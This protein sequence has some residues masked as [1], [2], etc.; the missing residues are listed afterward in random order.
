MTTTQ[1]DTQDSNTIYLILDGNKTVDKTSF[2]AQISE[3]LK[4]PD[5][6]SAN[7]DA[8]NDCLNHPEDWGLDV[9]YI[10]SITVLWLDPISFSEYNSADFLT[11]LDIL[12]AFTE[13]KNNPL[14]FI[15]GTNVTKIN[16]SLYR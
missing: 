16:T 2:L 1:I 11:A 3:L 9:T 4:F 13:D 14:S 6:F 12:K 8:L 15:V 7:W 5:Y 10:N